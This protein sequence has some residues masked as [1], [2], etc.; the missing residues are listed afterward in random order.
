MIS[1]KTKYA[2]QAMIALARSEQGSVVNIADL[3][4]ARGIPQRFL[5]Q[6]LLVLKHNAL[7]ASRRGPRGGYILIKP[8]SEITIGSIVRMIEGPIAPL[9]CLSKRAYRRCDDCR[10]EASCEIR[11]IF[12]EVHQATTNILDRVTLQDAI[13]DGP[14][15]HAAIAEAEPASALPA[16]LPA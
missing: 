13:S 2:L 12:F 6:I 15:W 16:T 11:R 10:D 14:L 3:A 9:P 5:E 7:V 4:E 1:Q 8:A